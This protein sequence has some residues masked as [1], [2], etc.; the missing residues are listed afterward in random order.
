MELPEKLPGTGVRNLVRRRKPTAQRGRHGEGL[1]HAIADG[2]YADLLRFGQARYVRRRR[3]PDSQRLERLVML[4]IGKVHRGRERQTLGEAR[5]PRRAGGQLPQ[6]HQFVRLRIM[7]RLQHHGIQHAEDC[8]IG[9][10]S[11]GQ[12]EQRDCRERRVL[13]QGAQSIAYVA[14]QRIQDSDGIH[15]VYLLSNLGGVAELAVGGG[16]RLRLRHSAGDVL[17][18][19]DLDVRFHLVESL[20]I[21]F[22]PSQKIPPVHRIHSAAGF[23]I[24]PIARTTC[25]QRAVCAVNCFLP[26]GV[27]R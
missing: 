5:Q 12:R 6:R 9:P 14:D 3:D 17:V 20:A 1:E 27:R 21:P 22:R 2:D 15:A 8:R 11:N 25:S 24:R 23:R 10:D 18:G 4:G 16:A 7:Q 19:L 13:G 26:S